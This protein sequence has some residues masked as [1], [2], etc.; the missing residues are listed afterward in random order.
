MRAEGK[1]VIEGHEDIGS[2]T[3]GIFIR[4]DVL[5]GRWDVNQAG[6]LL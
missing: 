2:S 1:T 4:A 5:A 6:L 3:K